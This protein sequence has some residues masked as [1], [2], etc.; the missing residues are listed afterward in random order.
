MSAPVR[1]DRRRFL[2]AAAAL[3]AGPALA[4]VRQGPIRLIAGFPAGGSL[5]RIARLIATELARVTSR[6]TI[7]ENVAGANSARAIA[8]VVASEPTGDTLLMGSSAL[9]HPD[10]AA[11]AE[12]LRPVV[13]VSTV[14]MVLVVRATMPVHDPKAFAAY[15]ARHPGAAY[16]SS[17][18]GNAS[19]LAAAYLM[20]R[21]GVEATHVPYSG[22][23]PAFADLVAGRLDFVMTGA[24]SSLGQHAQVRTLAVT[25]KVRSRLPGLETLP[26]IAETLVPDFDFSLWQAVYA[27]ARTPDA[28]VAELG[29]QL[30][31][32]LASTQLRSALADMG[33]ETLAG[34]A[35]DAHRLLQDESRR[36]RKV[37][38][39]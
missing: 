24:N 27:P 18:V 23:S 26:T 14:P 6:S 9:A 5:D 2:L 15:I 32:A 28:T 16:G 7:V 39:S 34:T 31:E 33:V 30:R 17:G 37:I 8:R 1:R 36:M 25:T 19:H 3:A 38:G 11:G 20:E 13:L 12:A 35:D 10:N 22:S 21:L 29:A 4:Q